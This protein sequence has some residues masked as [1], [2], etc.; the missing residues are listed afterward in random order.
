M[1]EIQIDKE[2]ETVN[3]LTDRQIDECRDSEK[4]R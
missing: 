3:R 1:T 4:E 2:N